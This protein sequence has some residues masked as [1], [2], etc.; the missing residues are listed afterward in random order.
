MQEKKEINVEIGQ[1]LKFYREAAGLTQEV[2][3]EM[4]GLGVKHVSAMERG[5][6]G[7]SVG[8]LMKASRI[9]GVPVDYFLFGEIGESERQTR[10][11]EAQLL[12]T[13][14]CRLTPER[15]EAVKGILNKLLEIL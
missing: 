7:V 8:T 5:A 10:E 1:R 13:K 4:V 2:F 3:A 14:L 9:L 11:R 12:V 6:N 15:Y